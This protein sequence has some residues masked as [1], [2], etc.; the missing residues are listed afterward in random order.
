MDTDTT[1]EPGMF[2]H[3]QIGKNCSYMHSKAIVFAKVVIYI[4][5]FDILHIVN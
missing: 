3:L 5:G 1:T 2:R 4:G